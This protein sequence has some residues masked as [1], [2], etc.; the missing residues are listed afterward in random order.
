MYTS[1][2]RKGLTL[3]FTYKLVRGK[4]ILY[5][6]GGERE[7]GYIY[8]Y[9]YMITEL[10]ITILVT[11]NPKNKICKIIVGFENSEV[12]FLNVVTDT[13]KK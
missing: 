11:I 2:F 8:T 7:R 13:L 10:T 1:L 9:N 12:Q 4:L 6:G 5:K 3:F